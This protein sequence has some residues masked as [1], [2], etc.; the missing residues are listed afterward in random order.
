MK[1]VDSANSISISFHILIRYRFKI[2]SFQ[3]VLLK[4]F[5]HFDHLSL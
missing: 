4:E 3:L 1:T 5:Q 2:K